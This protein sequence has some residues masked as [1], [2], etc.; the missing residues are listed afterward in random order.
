[1]EF[2][3][4][5]GEGTKRFMDR[6]EFNKAV[7]AEKKRELEKERKR[8]E[9]YQKAKADYAIS[10]LDLIHRTESENGI[11]NHEFVTRDDNSEKSRKI[12]EHEYMTF[13]TAFGHACPDTD[14]A[15]FVS[16]NFD[17]VL[18]DI[19]DHTVALHDCHNHRWV[20]V[21]IL[22]NVSYGEKLPRFLQE[23]LTE[24]YEARKQARK[25]D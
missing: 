19:M 25:Q 6:K 20:G 18:Q 9:L 14:Y 22:G 12:W 15:S 10:I 7:R 3:L 11:K 5:T 21:A 1:M 13:H 17:V 24:V 16:R 4:K 2:I 23:I 8:D